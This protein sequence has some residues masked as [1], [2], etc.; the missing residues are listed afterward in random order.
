M[1]I[2]PPETPTI[3]PFGVDKAKNL[4]MVCDYHLRQCLDQGQNLSALREKPTSEFSDHKGMR[5][6]FS[7]EEEL[8][9]PRM[10]MTEMVDPD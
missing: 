6:D 8:G 3:E 10:A 1:H 4:E 9:K 7:V 5:H 2:N